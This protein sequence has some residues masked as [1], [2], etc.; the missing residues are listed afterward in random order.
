MRY[1][2]EDGSGAASLTNFGGSYFDGGHANNYF[3][4]TMNIGTVFRRTDLTQA[5][6]LLGAYFE[7]ISD[8][9]YMG[10]ILSQKVGEGHNSR[11]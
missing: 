3:E 5:N 8:G 4:H 10:A 2:A 1:S 11:I 7:V 9:E 6:K